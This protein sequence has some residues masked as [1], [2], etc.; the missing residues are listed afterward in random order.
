VERE[1]HCFTSGRG[2][3]H[4]QSLLEILAGVRPSQLSGFD[5]LSSNVLQRAGTLSSVVCV[6]LDW[7]QARKSLCCR[8]LA[9][10]LP[11]DVFLVRATAPE[12]IDTANL[13]PRHI[14]PEQLAADLLWK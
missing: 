7:D 2:V 12:P 9:L 5:V 6:V 14:R 3:A 13:S 11:V 8:L 1:A 10:G 4:A